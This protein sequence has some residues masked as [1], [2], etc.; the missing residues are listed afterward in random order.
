[1]PIML[2]FGGE[3]RE[4]LFRNPLRRIEWQAYN[5]APFKGS[6]SKHRIITPPIYY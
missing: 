2:F 4:N 6:F 3:K 5:I 1:M